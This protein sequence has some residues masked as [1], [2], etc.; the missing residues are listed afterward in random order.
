MSF[1]NLLEEY[2]IFNFLAV[3]WAVSGIICIKPIAPA[4]LTAPLAKPLSCL[5]K[6]WI[7]LEFGESFILSIILNCFL[8]K[9]IFFLLRIDK[10]YE[11]SLPR[12]PLPLI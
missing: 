11:P 5:I 12:L 4:E 6:A 2:L 3:C 7:K 1:F 8:M 10:L 9:K